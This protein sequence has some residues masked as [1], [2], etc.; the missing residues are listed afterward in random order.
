LANLI[1][2]AFGTLINYS[3]NSLWT[4]RELPKEEGFLREDAAV[5]PDTLPRDDPHPSKDPVNPL[6]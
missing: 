5:N 2:I 4:W 1:G 3:M 6:F